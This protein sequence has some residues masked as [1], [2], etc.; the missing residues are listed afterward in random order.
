MT[1][2]LRVVSVQRGFDPADFSLL[3]FG[4]AGGLHACALAEKLGMSRVIFPVASGA[5]SALGMLAGRQQGDFSRTRRMPLDDDCTADILSDLFG[6]LKQEAQAAMQG[7]DLSFELRVDMSYVG[8]GF[9]MTVD[10]CEDDQNSLQES[11]QHSFELAHQQAYGHLLDRPVEIITLRL[12]A[13][14]E[15]QRLAPPKCFHGTD[16]QASG[17]SDIYGVGLVPHYRRELLPAGFNCSGPALVV[18]DTSTLWLPEQ[19]QMQVD[20]YGHLILERQ[21]L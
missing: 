3:C 4:G 9:H 1:G 17:E 15:R 14:V 18:E 5:F 7:L 12:T 2:A 19:W 20:A 10:M 11:L 13:L 6:E 16:V 8:Q 21:C